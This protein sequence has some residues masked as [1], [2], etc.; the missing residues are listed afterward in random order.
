MRHIALIMALMATC[1]AQGAAE[2]CSDECLLG[3]AGEGSLCTL[4]DQGEH[5]WIETP[6][7]GVGQL[8]NRARAYLPWLREKLMPAGGVMSATFTDDS[9]QQVASYGG[10][11]DAAIWTG[12]YLAAESLRLMSTGAADAFTQ[13]LETLT[14]LHRWWNIPGDPGYLARFAAPSSSPP[15]IK[16]TLPGED[17]EV[18]QRQ[19]YDGVFWDWRNDVSRD[20]YQGVLLGYALAYEALAPYQEDPTRGPAAREA[21]E[22]LRADVVEFAEQLMQRERRE[23][24]L[25]MDGSEQR[26]TLELENVV[27]LQ[28]A[29]P[30]GV[31][32][33]EIDM[34]SGDV[35]GHG[36]LVF[37]PDPARYLR[38]I[39][40]F[41][42]LPSFPLPTQA[43]QLGAAF[44]VALRLSAD[45]PGY[46][47]R[48]QALA[49]YYA[50][51]VEAWLGIAE[52]WSDTNRCGNGYHGL[53][54]G[55]MPAYNWTRLETDPARRERLRQRLLAERMWPAVAED[56]NVFFAFLY[57]SQ[58]P[59]G[60]DLASLL[61]EPIAQLD[62]FPVAPNQARAVDLMG[63]Y[64]QNPDCPGL[65]SVAVDVSQRVPATFIWERQ[66]WK[67][68]D[69]GVPYRLY[70]GVDFL[71][72]YWMGRAYGFLAEDAP[73]TCLRPR[74]ATLNAR[75][76][77]EI[78]QPGSHQTGIGLVSGWY[79][80]AQTLEISLDDGPRRPVAYGTERADTQLICGDRDN[81]FGFLL[82][83]NDLADGQHR[84]QV[85][86][87]GQPA[88]QAYFT[89]N[90]LGEAFRNDLT[91][92]AWLEQFPA[93]G[94]RT[95]LRWQ[96]ANQGFVI[97]GFE[98][99]ATF[100]AT[101]ASALPGHLEI[102]QP[103]SSQSGIGLISGWYCD[104]DSVAIQIDDGPLKTAGYGTERADTQAVCGDS[105]NGFGYLINYN[106]L[107][108]GAHQISAYAD[109]QLFASASFSVQTLGEPFIT[110]LSAQFPI[111]DF[112][113]PGLLTQVGWQ[114]A[115]QGF[116][117]LGVEPQ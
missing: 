26:L 31:P 28:A 70:G 82:N 20:Q 93:P 47:A 80:D 63:Q 35:K 33:L 92:E 68:Q 23:V 98:G 60:T 111:T 73:Q 69:P 44:Q 74:P 89:V 36:V 27:Y 88:A 50:Q 2:T 55:F 41:G 37:W 1:T 90:T 115:N 75:G 45:V 114:Q 85:W 108:D 30:D 86:L 66:P 15:A 100:Q 12:S 104:A 24:T 79:C 64:P 56:K 7:T 38:Q 62:G 16:A 29:M 94:Q 109:G 40:G 9:H 34:R 95:R 3:V 81:G 102:P 13:V 4:W 21:L 91:A 77:L 103:G 97:A 14:T 57:A 78:P 113:A 51:Q 61:A 42:W 107:G 105:N 67:L 58:A 59:D 87:D 72:A 84:V 6:D 54:I 48:H 5:R 18:Y 96:S 83:Y 65:S 32:T 19:L 17:D 10:E 43:I 110:G 39:P 46:E 53:N 8:H 116:T 106:E 11:R 71:L 99:G 117:I 76:A 22:A 52:Q 49:D 25:I 101:V 112:P